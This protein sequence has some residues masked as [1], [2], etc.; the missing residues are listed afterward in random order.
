M[1]CLRF[2]RFMTSKLCAATF[3]NSYVKWRLHYVML[4]FVAV[5]KKYHLVSR[6][7]NRSRWLRSWVFLLFM[8]C[9][10]YFHWKLFLFCFYL[11]RYND[12]IRVL[13]IRG[14]KVFLQTILYTGKVLYLSIFIRAGQPIIFCESDIRYIVR[15]TEDM[16]QCST[17]RQIFELASPIFYI[18]I[19][20][21]SRKTVR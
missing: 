8:I 9:Y 11:K 6:Y 21:K 1:W 15:Q 13:S 14:T 12:S 17:V 3:S 4:R 5:S 20:R 2:V 7:T 18:P 10:S 16:V 19:V